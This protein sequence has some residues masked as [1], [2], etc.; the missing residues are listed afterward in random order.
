MSLDSSTQRPRHYVVAI[1]GA[2]GAIYA[3]RALEELARFVGQ[4]PQVYGHW[5][6]SQ[7][8]QQVW[9]QELGEPM[10]ERVDGIHRWSTQ[11]FSAPFAS[12]SNAASATLVAPC[13][14]STLGR[15]ASGSG[16]GLIHRA[17]DVALKERK[18]LILMA[19]ET[20]LSAIH[21][22]NMLTVSEAGALVLP[23]V[24]SFYAKLDAGRDP[25]SAAIDSVVGRALDHMGIHHQLLP[26]WGDTK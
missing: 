3:K 18:P 19:R 25:L 2:S 11:D 5:I 9:A 14:M 23:A 7:A 22:R 13:S 6:A 16:T 4:T 8:A 17:C 20:P 26:R 12:G 1:T 10:P 21:L 24:P 15:I